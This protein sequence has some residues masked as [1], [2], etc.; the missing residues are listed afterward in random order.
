MKAERM[1][2]G[3]VLLAVLASLTVI[4]FYFMIVINKKEQVL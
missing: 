3:L 1:I 2:E 4:S